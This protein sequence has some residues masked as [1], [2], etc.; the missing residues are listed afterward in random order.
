MRLAVCFLREPLGDLLSR[1]TVIVVQVDDHGCQRQPLVAALRTF[2]H[3][4]VEAAK[5]PFEVIGY[6]LAV[7]AGQMVHPFVNRAQ[8][9]GATLRRSSCRSTGGRARHRRG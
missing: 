4:L 3:D 6:Q 2:L 5:Q 1:H 7:L 8:R 9:T